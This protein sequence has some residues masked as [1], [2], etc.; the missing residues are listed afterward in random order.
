MDAKTKAYSEK[1]HAELQQTKS[2]LKEFETRSK[3]QDQQ[4]AMD[5]INQLKKTHHDIEM[6]NEEIKNSALEEMEQEQAEIDAGLAKLRSGLTQL[7]AKL[8][9]EPRR[10]VS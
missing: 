2:R 8:K 7:D 3:A 1:V 5:L 6:K 4:V 9:T 10:K